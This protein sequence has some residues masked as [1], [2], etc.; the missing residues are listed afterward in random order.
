[1]AT[2][3]F[4][5]NTYDR[6]YLQLTITS[7]PNAITNQSTLSWTLE[8]IGGNSTYYTI[9]KTTIV[10]AG[11]TV[12]S[13]AQT[14]W[15][16]R[17]FPAKKGSTSGTLTVDHGSD[18]KKT[19][20][21]SF[22]TRVYIFEPLEYGGNMTLDNIDRTAPTV[23]CAT[24]N[25]TS[26]G[27]KIAG[28]SN[29]T[30]DIWQYSL[31]DGSTWTQYS[32]TAGT[33]ASTTL[34]TLKPNTT[35]KVNV[36]AR[37]KS[38]QVYG[39]SAIK[40]TKTLGASVIVNTNS[41]AAD[42]DSPVCKFNLTVY[43]AGYYHR[44]TIK[45]WST[46]IFS[47][48]LGKLTAGTADRTYSL[49]AKQRADL[50]DAFPNNTSHPMNLLIGTY[51]DSSYSTLIGSESS[52]AVT[53]T[54]SEAVSK[55]SF[56][57]FTY[58][59][60]KTAVV[61]ITDDNQVLVKNLS[62]LKVTCGAG[63]AKNGA[64]IKSYSASIANAS[65]TSTTTTILLG[66]ITKY[67][68]L[69]LTVTCTDSRG[70][71]TSLTATIKVLNYE[72]PKLNRFTLR[73]KDEIE[74]LIQLYF[75]GTR[76]AI[77]ADGSTD[78]NG[79][80]Y[81]RYR[82]KKTTE[83]TYSSYVSILADVTTSGTS[84][85]FASLELLELDAESS[86]DFHLQIRDKFGSTTS[87]DIES[88][89]PQGTPVVSL[90]KRNN[91][92]D[93]PRV[94]INNPNPKHALDVAGSV[95]MNGFLVLGYVKDLTTENFNTLKEGIFFYPGSGCS[96]APVDAPGFLEAI[97]NGTVILHRFTTL[98]GAVYNRGYDGSTWTA[99]A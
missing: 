78:T 90:R 67:G 87:L 68:D 94:G 10:I 69:T 13:K 95:A 25:I 2:A 51:S 44:L 48:N 72:N 16:D 39:T 60:T 58:E 4:K 34:T 38:N 59:D 99:W 56:T 32:S 26:A 63:T 12:Y 53:V 64:T 1:M 20:E 61:N 7:T 80:L 77:K 14:D 71:A 46:E 22:N 81:A 9:G 88:V 15:E 66:A 5:S 47:V 54:T 6:R 85:S 37:K 91:T 89:I 17:V 57:S 27:F 49:T 50:L 98:A 35:Y 55:P 42:V 28:T 92:Y 3:T 83:D 18:G 11:K 86:Y 79:L 84:F 73:R 24:S 31:D 23:T 43:D 40:A 97:T 30:A 41:F 36:R 19:I 65:K 75:G 21:V 76:S 96:N 82:Y 29:V 33:T 45:K 62:S 74:G 93:H 70:Y 8:S 52:K